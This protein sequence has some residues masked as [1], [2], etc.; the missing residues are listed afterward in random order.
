MRHTLGMMC[1]RIVMA[2]PGAWPSGTVAGWIL[3]WAGDY[4]NEADNA[5]YPCYQRRLLRREIWKQQ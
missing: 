3:A 5:N 2:W 4:A 1:W